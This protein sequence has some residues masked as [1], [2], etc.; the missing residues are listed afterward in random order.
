MSRPSAATIIPSFHLLFVV[1]LFLLV[2]TWGKSTPLFLRWTLLVVGAIVVLFHGSKILRK[3]GK[4]INVAHALLI[5]PLLVYIG[6]HKTIMKGAEA[7][8]A[9]YWA[10]IVLAIAAAIIHGLKIKRV[11]KLGSGT[12]AL[13]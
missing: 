13:S 4:P 10:L 5:G 1:P 3:Q 2:G 12:K 11:A 9:T 8:D 6:S 7:E